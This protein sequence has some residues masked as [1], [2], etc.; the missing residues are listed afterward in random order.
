VLWFVDR[1]WVLLYLLGSFVAL[2]FGIMGGMRLR[3]ARLI[4]VEEGILHRQ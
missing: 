1:P 3:R 2:A 4:H